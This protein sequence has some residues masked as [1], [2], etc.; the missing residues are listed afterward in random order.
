MY[1]ILAESTGSMTQAV[2]DV[3]GV[4]STVMSTITG[5]TI[6]MAFF[7]AGIIGVAIA[8]VRKLKR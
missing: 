4:V 6:L 1:T 8:I 2:S 5:N 7:C 3:M